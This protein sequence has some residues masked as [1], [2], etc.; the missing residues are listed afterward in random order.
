[1]IQIHPN[2][3]S[4]LN[5]TSIYTQGTNNGLSG[6]GSS[7]LHAFQSARGIAQGHQSLPSTGGS[8]G[9]HGG[10][11]GPGSGPGG[12][13]GYDGPA[14]PPGGSGGSA[15]GP[16][17][18]NQERGRQ[19]SGSSGTTKVKDNLP[20]PALSP[21]PSSGTGQAFGDMHH[22]ALSN[23]KGRPVPPQTKLGGCTIC[24]CNKNKKK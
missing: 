16:P 24:S 22:K 23:A 13:S 18:G 4:I 11:A 2:L 15:G 20:G 8:G 12:A 21:G 5:T 10:A 1:M 6:P 3:A 14:A 17:A 19:P 7:V 9:T